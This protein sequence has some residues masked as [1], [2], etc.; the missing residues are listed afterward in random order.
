MDSTFAILIY[1]L[2]CIASGVFF[3]FLGY[4]L[5]VLGI[6]GNAGDLDSQFHNTKLVLKKAAPGTFFA[7]FGAVIIGGT[8]MQ[9]L[10]FKESLA[11]PEVPAA[12]VTK[13]KSS[14][15]LAPVD[16]QQTK[17]NLT[18]MRVDA[19]QTIAE[20]N[21]LPKLLRLDVPASKLVITNK[22]IRASK[23]AIVISVWGADW[24]DVRKFKNWVDGGESEAVSS[25][26]EPSVAL[27][28]QGE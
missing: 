5:F 21:N 24:G 26:L 4:R 28:R 18:S 20:L 1:K 23:R 6:F 14:T 22:A 13:T 12:S 7:L 11:G 16:P 27:F 10:G 2:I 25:D 17:A 8:I 3:C 19:E 15:G 9:G